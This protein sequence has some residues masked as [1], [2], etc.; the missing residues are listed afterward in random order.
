[1]AKITKKRTVG[2]AGQLSAAAGRSQ[3]PTPEQDPKPL[4]ADPTSTSSQNN[5]PSG[6]SKQSS[7]KAKALPKVATVEP[8][9][10]M[11]QAAEAMQAMSANFGNITKALDTFQS[12]ASWL[13]AHHESVKLQEEV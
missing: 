9:P 13:V 4:A 2:Q 12:Q 7:S 10:E 5:D 6:S 1:M 11:A 8:T 3:L